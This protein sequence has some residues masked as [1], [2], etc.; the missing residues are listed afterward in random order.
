[1]QKKKNWIF[2]NFLKSGYL[3]HKLKE[4]F[5]CKKNWGGGN[6]FAK[7]IHLNINFRPFWIVTVGIA[8]DGTL[9][10]SFP[11]YSLFEV[12]I[13]P[14]FTL[15]ETAVSHLNVSYLLAI[16]VLMQ[17]YTEPL[18]GERRFWKQMLYQKLMCNMPFAKGF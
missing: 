6:K 1:M 10:H 14:F 4:M 13:S 15:Q 17:Y 2:R 11:K 7:Q 18:S 12:E 9:H 16:Y 3:V 5:Q 8:T